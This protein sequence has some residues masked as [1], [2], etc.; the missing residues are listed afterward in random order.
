M[1]HFDDKGNY[2]IDWKKVR[3]YVVPEDLDQFKV[4]LNWLSDGAWSTHFTDTAQ[5]TP[6]VTKRAEP[7]RSDYTKEIERNGKTY[8]VVDSL[9]GHDYLQLWVDRNGEEVYQHETKEYKER[10]ESRKEQ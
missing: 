8:T 7:K 2:V 1:G 5:L 10:N 9:K 3:T 4:C 6:F